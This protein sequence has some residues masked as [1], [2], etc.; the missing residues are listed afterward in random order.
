M[1]NWHEIFIIHYQRTHFETGH[2]YALWQIILS[3]SFSWSCYIHKHII[4]VNGQNKVAFQLLFFSPHKW[5][6]RLPHTHHTKTPSSLSMWL[7]FLENLY[8]FRHGYWIRKLRHL[9]CNA[10]WFFFLSSRFCCKHRQLLY[11]VSPPK[12]NGPS[13]RKTKSQSGYLSA[14]KK[15]RYE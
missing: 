15:K 6:E 14:L 1:R 12:H 3:S 11:N 2:S 5:N 10:L 7:L 13:N 8:Q 9:I 4:I